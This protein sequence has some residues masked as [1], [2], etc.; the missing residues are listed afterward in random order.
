MAYEA[1]VLAILET[2]VIAD[3]HVIA[4]LMRHRWQEG[5]SSINNAYKALMTLSAAGK[6]VKGD[7]YFKLPDCKSEYKEHS[8]KLT[9]CIAEIL[10]TKIPSQISREPTIPEIGL[11]PDCLVY[12]EKNGKGLCWVLEVCR[13]EKE[14]YLIQ[15]ITAWKA[16]DK[17]TEFL[18]TN[19][20]ARIPVF[21]IV[22]EGLVVDRTFEF[23]SYLKEATI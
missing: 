9:R 5:T 7:G 8:Q 10:K 17:A 2:L 15:K 14:E 1:E 20:N 21:D 12:M 22:V 11:R 19:F 23:Y 18:S 3:K 4:S 13:K 16:W 6:I